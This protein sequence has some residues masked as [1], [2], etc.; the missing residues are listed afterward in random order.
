[1]IK[2]HPNEGANILSNG[3]GPVDLVLALLDIHGICGE[4]DKDLFL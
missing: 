1:M 3:T 2:F 4:E